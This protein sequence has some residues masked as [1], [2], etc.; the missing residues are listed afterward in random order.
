MPCHV[1]LAECEALVRDGRIDEIFETGLHE[2]I[3]GF[4]ARNQ[5]LAAQVQRDY[6]FTD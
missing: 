3:G 6:R 4:I 2:F 5:G 1:M